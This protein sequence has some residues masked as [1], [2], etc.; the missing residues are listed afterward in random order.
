LLDEAYQE[1]KTL[2]SPTSIYALATTHDVIHILRGEYDRAFET[3]SPALELE[4]SLILSGLWIDIFQQLAWCYYDLG[5]YD[6]GL[7]HCQKAIGRHGSTNS[8][9]RAPAFAVLALLQIRCGNLDEADAAVMEGW[10]NFDLGWQTYYGWWETLSILEA[11][12][13]LALARGELAR[14]A[15]CTDQLLGKYDELKLRHFKPGILYLRA[16][17]ELAAENND[18]AHQTLSDALALSDEMGAHREVW[19]MCWALTELETERGDGA[20]AGQLLERAYREVAFI[21]EH[22]GSP[23]LREIFLSRPDVQLVLNAD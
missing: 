1:N 17:V 15:R 4:E 11:E 23:E 21:A 6:L 22:A 14:A 18:Q 9:G 16:R 19:R 3:L 7:E 2:G 5:A 13:R 8:T 10:K 12:A 20:V